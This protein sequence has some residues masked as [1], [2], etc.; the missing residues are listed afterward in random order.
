NSIIDFADRNS[1]FDSPEVS[2]S[3][4]NIDQGPFSKALM[5]FTSF[6]RAYSS[7][8][9]NRL[10]ES[11]ITR[12]IPYLLMNIILEANL[13]NLRAVLYGGYSPE[14]V[15]QRWKE[16]PELMMSYVLSRVPWVGPWTDLTLSFAQNMVD[17]HAYDAFGPSIVG[18]MV[19]DFM[20][21]TQKGIKSLW[22]EDVE[23]S[24]ADRKT[25]DRYLPIWNLPYIRIVERALQDFEDKGE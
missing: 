6:A 19:D 23:L 16:D 13:M 22:D 15:Y 2:V 12:G 21:I 17:E 3:D 9:L 8:K 7:K 4:L 10:A 24:N 11:P 18:S 1:Y 5:Q 14:T 25:L 20:N